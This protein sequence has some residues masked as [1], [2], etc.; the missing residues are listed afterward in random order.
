VNYFL[1]T[2]QGKYLD[3]AHN[4]NQLKLSQNRYTCMWLSCLCWT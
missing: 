4:F 2:I 1:Y 3:A